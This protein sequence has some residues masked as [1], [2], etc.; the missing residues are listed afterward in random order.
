MTATTGNAP[1][2]PA[3]TTAV[4]TLAA[5]SMA[6]FLNDMIQSLIPAIYPVIKESYA[7]DFAQIGLITLTFQIAGSLLQP[8]VGYVTDRRPMPY[9][10]LVGMT[11]TLAGLAI[12]GFA[13]THLDVARA[14]GSPTTHAHE[15][16][17]R[18]RALTIL[19]FFTQDR[20]PVGQRLPV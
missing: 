12:L 14:T 2:G 6:H 17:K 8:V 15:T 11:F 1:L 4:A 9:A 20:G 10:T 16:G 3:E 7:L 19:T 5:I 13:S 18:A